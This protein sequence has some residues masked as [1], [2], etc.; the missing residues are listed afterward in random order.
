MEGNPKDRIVPIRDSK[1]E[2]IVLLAIPPDDRGG[3]PKRWENHAYYYAKCAYGSED[4][5]KALEE[6]YE[7][8]GTLTKDNLAYMRKPKGRVP[9]TES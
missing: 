7:Q 1:G 3:E 8:F 6:A 4:F 9:P 2:E 5:D